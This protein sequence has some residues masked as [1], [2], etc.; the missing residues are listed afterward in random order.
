MA[1]CLRL[2]NAEFSRLALK[3]AAFQ[4]LQAPELPKK[5]IASRSASTIIRMVSTAEHSFSECRGGIEI[6]FE[7]AR[8]A[9]LNDLFAMGMHERRRYRTA[10]HKLISNAVLAKYNGH[11]PR[12]SA[13]TISLTRIGP[14]A[15]DPDAIIP[16]APIDG[17]RYAGFLPD[18]TVAVVRALSLHQEIGSY[19]VN[20]RLLKIKD[21]S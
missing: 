14:R 10:W 15:V 11:P 1:R 21:A 2:S 20:I 6:R 9:T 17:L 7:G 13:A 16:K 4:V 8:L 12:F 3:N 18:D 19:A 5:P